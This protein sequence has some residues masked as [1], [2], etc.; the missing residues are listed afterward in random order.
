MKLRAEN[1]VADGVREGCKSRLL[2]GLLEGLFCWGLVVWGSGFRLWGHSLGLG[3]GQD[4]PS[5][6]KLGRQPY[7]TP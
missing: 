4:R 1:P 7:M 5:H 3:S 6:R 2:Q